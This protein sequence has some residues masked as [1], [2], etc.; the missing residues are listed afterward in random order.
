MNKKKTLVKEIKR[1]TKRFE[2]TKICKK[3]KVKRETD[4]KE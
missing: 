1:E 4:K 2:K 3:I